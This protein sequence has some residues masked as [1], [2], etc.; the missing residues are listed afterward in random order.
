MITI[1]AFKWVP[2]FAQ[3]QVRD[4]RVR[5][6]LE[7]VG[8]PYRVRLIDPAVQA[9]AEYREEQPFGQV[10]VFEEDGRSLFETGAI[11][12]HLAE[13]TGKLL[14]KDP[15]DRALAIS[16]LFASLNSVEPFLMNLAEVD[17]F[18][19]DE[20]QKAK[21]RPGV[22]KMVE[23]R[24]GD[25]EKALGDR[26]YLVGDFSIADLMMTTVLRIQ[27]H[28]D[29]LAAYPKL[30]AYKRRNTDRPA[31]KKAHA[32]QCAAFRDHAP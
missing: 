23:T 6:A 20:D 26:E 8:L 7:E 11:V 32:E 18:M 31:F 19:K 17:F 4:L 30:A 10:P 12:L 21:R 24:F 9:S 5:W 25:V 29:L 2:P 3:G 1:S 13:R 15:Y 16:W 22:I 14:P 28:A 27:D